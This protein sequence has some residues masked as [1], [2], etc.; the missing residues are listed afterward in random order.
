LF[1]KPAQCPPSFPFFLA[2]ARGWPTWR[3][4]QPR[5]A[6]A[7]MARLSLH[8]ELPPLARPVPLRPS[9]ARPWRTAI[10]A[11]AGAERLSRPRVPRHGRPTSLHREGRLSTSYTLLADGSCPLVWQPPDASNT[12]HGGSCPSSR[13]HACCALQRHACR[14]A[15]ASPTPA[16]AG[17]QRVAESPTMFVYP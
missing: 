16:F 3:R 10:R 13:T 6:T 12:L 17:A 15:C 7:P 1:G 11:M 2:P 9:M 14:H 5:V 8:T 4:G